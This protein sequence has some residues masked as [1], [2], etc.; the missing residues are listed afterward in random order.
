MFS[1]KYKRLTQ[2]DFLQIHLVYFF[3]GPQGP[4]GLKGEPGVRGY[5]GLPVSYLS[6]NFLPLSGF[7]I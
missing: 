2:I 5:T 6:F 1:K 4:I 3:Q 7:K